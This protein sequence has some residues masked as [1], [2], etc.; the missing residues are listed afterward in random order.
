MYKYWYVL[1]ENGTIKSLM[2]AK[3]CSN[4]IQISKMDYEKY[5]SILADIPN[6]AGY[7]KYVKLYPDFTYTVEYIL[8]EEII[9]E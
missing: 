7:D 1:N 8:I 9:V 3:L 4:G 6:K 2:K 5:K